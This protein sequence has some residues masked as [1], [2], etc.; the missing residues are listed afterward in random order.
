[1][2]HYLTQLYC[3]FKLLAELCCCVLTACYGKNF[4]PKGYGHGIGAGTLQMSWSGN[5][6]SEHYAL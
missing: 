6:D 1:M 5:L 4:A 3:L 2:W